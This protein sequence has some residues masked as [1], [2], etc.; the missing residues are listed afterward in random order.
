[1]VSK[2]SFFDICDEL[3]I[4]VWQELFLACGL[5]PDTDKFL[6][7][8]D[9]ESKVVIKRIRRHPCNVMWCGGNELFNNWSK[10]TNQSLPL[11]LLDRNTYDYDRQT[12]YIMASPIDG[13]SH[14]HYIIR[15]MN[16][17]VEVIQNFINSDSTAYTEFG[18]GGPSPVEYIKKIM[19]E[20]DY[21]NFSEGRSW[22]AH[23][24]VKAWDK[25]SWIRMHEIES[26]FGTAS[27]EQTIENG[28]KLQS[29]GFRHLFEEARRQWPYCSMALNWC[30]NEPWPSAGN[31]S[32]INWPCE[33]KPAFYGVKNALRPHLASARLK[34]MIW[35]AGKY[36]EAE[37]WMLNDSLT[38]I[39]KGKVAA[40]ILINSEKI[41]LITWDYDK[42]EAQTNLPG[43][44]IKYLLPKAENGQFKLLLEVEN[45]PEMNSEYLCFCHVDGKP[46]K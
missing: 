4:M 28:T 44:I 41:K 34:G 18:A 22:E 14:G 11:R 27:F 10:M 31:N 7:V 36:F 42:V 26:Y 40:Y 29:E 24:A 16:T 23:H 43:P 20:E 12:P 17:G 35:Q 1:M 5:Y 37:L 46:V 13:M 8:L 32:L 45:H 15:D 30:L 39:E 6:D 19:P 9:K 21:N 38:A 2:D 33:P 25:H 3:G